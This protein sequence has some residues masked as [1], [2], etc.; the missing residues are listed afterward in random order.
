MMGEGGG[1]R[2][3]IIVA[4]KRVYCVDIIFLYMNSKENQKQSA[5]RKL[6]NNKAIEATVGEVK[7]VPKEHYSKGWN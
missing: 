1:G 4:I 7:Y 5:I 6:N 2:G 3:V